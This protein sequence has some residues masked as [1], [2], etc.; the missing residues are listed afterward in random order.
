MT[1]GHGE[2][3]LLDVPLGPLEERVERLRR[4]VEAVRRRE[5][6]QRSPRGPCVVQ[7]GRE[8]LAAPDW[9]ARSSRYR[10]V[11][12]TPPGPPYCASYSSR[13]RVP[14]LGQCQCRSFRPSF[15][16]SSRRHSSP[17]TASVPTTRVGRPRRPGETKTRRDGHRAGGKRLD[18]VEERQPLARGLAHGG[19]GQEGGTRGCEPARLGERRAP[20][21]EALGE[22]GALRLEPVAAVLAIEEELGPGAVALDAH[23]PGARALG[24]HQH[25]ALPLRLRARVDTRRADRALQP[26]PVDEVVPGAQVV[27]QDGRGGRR[28]RREGHQERGRRGS[29]GGIRPRGEAAARPGAGPRGPPPRGRSGRTS[30]S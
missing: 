20:L 25:V 30:S 12:S 18:L 5:R 17:A 27:A 3:E 2:D 4:E 16:P 7:P 15:P 21:R 1:P 10:S 14:L 29:H 19:P 26:L 23:A 24:E 11:T 8:P 22:R 13:P 28:R 9:E 6:L